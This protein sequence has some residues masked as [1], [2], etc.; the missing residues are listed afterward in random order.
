MITHHPETEVLFDYASGSMSEPMALSIAC[1]ASVCSTCRQQIQEL[2]AVG[3]ELLD[4]AAS[5][6]LDETSLNTVLGRLDETPT[7]F[8]PAPGPNFDE[9]TLHIVPGPLRHYLND[10]LSRLNWRNIGKK[11]SQ[12]NLHIDTGSFK[13]SIMRFK[14]GAPMPRHTHK[15]QEVTLVL[16]GGYSDEGNHFERGDFDLRDPSHIHQPH[17]DAG[18][19][20]YA[21]VVMD[22][23]VVLAGPISRFLNPFVKL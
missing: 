16:T 1:H 18:E 8:S 7:D 15:G 21:L 13:A 19:D 4:A 22:A 20:C 2:E 23:P 10:N 14:A 11:V 3:G 17:V 5:V 6:E 9:E 12:F